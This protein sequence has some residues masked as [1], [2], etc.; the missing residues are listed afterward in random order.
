MLHGKAGH[1]QEYARFAAEAEAKAKAKE[2]AAEA[3]A[4]EAAEA[5]A[6]LRPTQ[7]GAA[8]R[9]HLAIAP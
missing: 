6:A 2:E 5:A 1:K 7:G 3:E 8:P 9:A 4:T